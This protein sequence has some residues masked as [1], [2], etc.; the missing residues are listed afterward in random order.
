MVVGPA[1]AYLIYCRP[2]EFRQVHLQGNNASYQLKR[3]VTKTII[4]ILAFKLTSTHT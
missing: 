4:A 1:S 2:A 3:S